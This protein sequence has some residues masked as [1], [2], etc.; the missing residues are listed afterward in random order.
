VHIFHPVLGIYALLVH[1]PLVGCPVVIVLGCMCPRPSNN[2][3]NNNNISIEL[4]WWMGMSLRPEIIIMQ[5]NIYNNKKC[6]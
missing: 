6:G 5:P 4:E 1:T 2:V 3:N